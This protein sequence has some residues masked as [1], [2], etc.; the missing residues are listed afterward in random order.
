MRLRRALLRPADTNQF[1]LTSRAALSASMTLLRPARIDLGA[2]LVGIGFSPLS[3]LTVSLQVD[4]HPP[5]RFTLGPASLRAGT[6]VVSYNTLYLNVEQ[7]RVVAIKDSSGNM[8]A[9]SETISLSPAEFSVMAG[10]GGILYPALS[11][12]AAGA[13]LALACAAPRAEG[14]AR[15]AFRAARAV[16]TI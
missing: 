5:G 14:A 13:V 4:D 2:E 12:G 10:N 8:A 15:A 9:L 7:S 6:G 11:M 1:I 16:P 3:P